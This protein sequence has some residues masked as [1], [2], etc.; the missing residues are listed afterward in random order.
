MNPWC[1]ECALL[2]TENSLSWY[3]PHRAGHLAVRCGAPAAGA[4][5]L[6]QALLRTQPGFLGTVSLCC[7]ISFSL[8]APAALSTPTHTGGFSELPFPGISLV[9]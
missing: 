4:P 2:V 9:S 7:I 3:W 6:W 1:V 8:H 5:C